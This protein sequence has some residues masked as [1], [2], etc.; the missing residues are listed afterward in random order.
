MPIN[1]AL[2]LAAFAT[3][4]VIVYL[5]LSRRYGGHTGYRL[6]LVLSLLTLFLVVW[7][8]L[9]VGIVGEPD[10]PANLMYMG[11]SVVV[12]A[13]A[14]IVRFTPEGLARLLRAAAALQ[15]LV[16]LATIAF[17]FGRGEPIWPWGLLAFNAVLFVL[18]WSSGAAFRRVARHKLAA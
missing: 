10:H 1:V 18:W 4:F 7:V 8:N 9:A 15:A 2:A 3:P 13:G 11:L 17:G 12:V 5:I 16:A 14:L 6:G